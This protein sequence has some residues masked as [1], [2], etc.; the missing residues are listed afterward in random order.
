MVPRMTSDA[1]TGHPLTRR[2]FAQDKKRQ[3]TMLAMEVAI[4]EAGFSTSNLWNLPQDGVSTAW[5]QIRPTRTPTKEYRS[6]LL[7]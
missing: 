7:S 3:D 2:A 4:Q 1:L 5:I 6:E